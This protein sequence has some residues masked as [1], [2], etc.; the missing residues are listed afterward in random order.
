MTLIVAVEAQDGIVLAGDSRGTI[1]DP[2]GLTAINDSFDKIFKLSDYCGIG[3]S[4]ASELANKF[5]DS[6]QLKIKEKNLVKVDDIVDEIYVS[7]KEGYNKWF[8]PKPWYST[9]QQG[10]QIVDLRPVMTFVVCGYN[11]AGDNKSRIYILTS[12]FDFVPQ[13][14]TGGHMLAGVPQY[15]V[16][17]LHRL[18]NRQMKLENVTALSAYLITETAT[19]D[20]KVGGPVK[21]SQITADKGYEALKPEV[22][23]S[24][25]E[26]N[27]GQNIK[28][29]EF[30]FK[31]EGQ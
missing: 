30:F 28:L 10:G 19:Q 25:I 1:G 15:A 22:I 4:G 26:K 18:Y 21:I 8:G 20:P 17:L 27:D 7:G 24:I 6:L 16:Y 2:R 23:K 11:N 14:C 3:I 31:G 29:R 9:A 13:L 12:Q 5:I